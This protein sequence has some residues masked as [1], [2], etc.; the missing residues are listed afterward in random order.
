MKALVDRIIQHGGVEY[1]L[2]A[3]QEA[4][5]MPHALV[6]NLVDAGY[7]ERPP[8]VKTAARKRKEEV[9]DGAVTSE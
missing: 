6:D 4:P 2:Q 8:E 7:V 5:P 9:S 1:R 3:G